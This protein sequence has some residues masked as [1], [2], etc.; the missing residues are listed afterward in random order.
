VIVEPTASR[1]FAKSA[2]EYG[3]EPDDV[4]PLAAAQFVPTPDNVS[5][6]AMVNATASRGCTKRDLL[7]KVLTLFIWMT[8]FAMYRTDTKRCFASTGA[9][10]K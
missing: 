10:G 2:F 8:T 5:A 9:R 7:I 4:A 6:V 1:V 3:H